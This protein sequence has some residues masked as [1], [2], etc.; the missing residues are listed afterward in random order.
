M[1]VLVFIILI[2]SFNNITA[3]H[4]TYGHGIANTESNITHIGSDSNGYHYT[5]YNMNGPV[6]DAIDTFDLPGN[7]FVVVKYDCNN[8]IIW[9]KKAYCDN[10]NGKA[11]SGFGIQYGATDKWGNTYLQGVYI[12]N[13]ISTGNFL[14]DSNITHTV[15]NITD[16][17]R[18]IY[19]LKIDSGGHLKWCTWLDSKKYNGATYGPADL[20]YNGVIINNKNEPELLVHTYETTYSN[21]L[22]LDTTIN[23]LVLTPRTMHMVVVNPLTGSVITAKHMD[24]HPFKKIVT[25]VFGNYSGVPNPI[26]YYKGNYYYSGL[27]VDSCVIG[28]DTIIGAPQYQGNGM[29]R[30]LIIKFD[31]IG[32]VLWKRYWFSNGE[33]SLGVI[34]NFQTC[35]DDSNVYE[36]LYFEESPQTPY[37]FYI[38]G[39][40]VN[41]TLDT[42][43]TF[44]NRTGALCVFDAHTGVLKKVM[45]FNSDEVMIPAVCTRTKRGLVIAGIAYDKSYFGNNIADTI[46]NNIPPPGFGYNTFIIE[47]DPNNNYSINWQTT[48][49]NTS[50]E[51]W[52]EDISTDIYGNVFLRGNGEVGAGVWYNGINYLTTPQNGEYFVAVGNPVWCNCI[53][54]KPNTNL[55]SIAGTIVTV[56]GNVGGAIVDSMVWYWGDGTSTVYNTPNSNISHTYSLAGNYTACLRVFDAC[57]YKDSCIQFT[58]LTSTKD[59]L[60]YVQVYP[61]PAQQVLYIDAPIANLQ[62]KLYTTTGT[63]VKHGTCTVGKNKVQLQGVTTGIYLLELQDGTSAKW[64]RKVAVE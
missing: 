20:Q 25:W 36:L 63:V 12:A 16:T 41:N 17:N 57:G 27:F 61:N 53:T 56:S 2:F 38:F 34:S 15:N 6:V 24:M 3:Q 22:Y 46:P 33:D 55:P 19:L 23:G 47:V 28:G 14:I 51:S 1:R 11:L 48:Y 43:N 30:N 62:Y 31:S 49:Q 29:Y 42:F 58:I 37:P 59:W 26:T 60:P 9:C 54:P 10:V 35:V 44:G 52:Y 7:G 4:L 64:W 45:P 18:N 21:G 50:F 40:S 8:N 39:N 13:S 32:N 5:V